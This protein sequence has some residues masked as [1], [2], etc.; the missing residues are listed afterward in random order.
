MAAAVAERRLL[1]PLD[2]RR[3]HVRGGP[4]G[5]RGQASVLVYSD[6]LCPYC[7]RLS[8]VLARLREALGDRLVYGY[9]QFPNER[10]HPGAEVLSRAAEAAGRQGKFWQ[11]HDA[12]FERSPAL[13]EAV[14]LDM[15]EKLKLDMARFRRDLDDPKL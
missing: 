4:A 3:D 10:V 15:A 5:V 13:T 6:Y 7:A 8:P 12:L 9:R 11:M 2:R 14:A 1:R